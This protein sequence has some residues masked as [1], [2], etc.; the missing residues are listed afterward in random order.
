MDINTV[1]NQVP[2]VDD[3][4][5]WGKEDYWATPKEFYTQRGG[6]C[7][8]YAIAKY[9]A[10][11]SIGI[12]AKD[13]FLT[14]G[15]IDDGDGIHMV[16]LIKSKD[17]KDTFILDNMVDKIKHFGDHP[18]FK[19]RYKLNEDELYIGD[20]K[21]SPTILPKWKALVTRMKLGK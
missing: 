12:P 15:D 9:F 3:M 6:D 7:E 13:M 11:R 5:V 17:G 2:S 21:L 16:L 20:I 19:T 4:E 18:S 8:D 1:V 14:V 10:L